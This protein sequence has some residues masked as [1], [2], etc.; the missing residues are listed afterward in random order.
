MGLAVLKAVAAGRVAAA[1]LVGRGVSFEAGAALIIGAAVPIRV[2]S[3]THA[4]ST[5]AAS[6]KRDTNFEYLKGTSSRPNPSGTDTN[7]LSSYRTVCFKST[8]LV[9]RAAIFRRIQTNEP[10]Q[11]PQM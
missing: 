1:G 11:G 3:G 8:L 6:S 10:A 9:E 2:A 4:A 5:T 7:Q